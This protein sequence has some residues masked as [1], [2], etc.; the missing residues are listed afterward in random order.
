[1]VVKYNGTGT[2]GSVQV[3]GSLSYPIQAR[4][5]SFEETLPNADIRA[6]PGHES[7]NRASRARGGDSGGI[8]VGNPLIGR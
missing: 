1:M 7:S 2:V 3:P 6:I 4:A 8:T 5:G